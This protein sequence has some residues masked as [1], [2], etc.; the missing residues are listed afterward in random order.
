V[1]TE[2]SGAAHCLKKFQGEEKSS[3]F[4]N[5]KI[6]ATILCFPGSGAGGV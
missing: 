5:R 4:W 6:F 1:V 2:K 3:N